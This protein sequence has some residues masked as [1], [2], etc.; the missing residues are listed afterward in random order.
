MTASN[1]TSRSTAAG[2]IAVTLALLAGCGPSRPATYPVT[3]KVVFPDGSTLPGGMV[4]FES[5]SAEGRPVNARGPIAEDGTFFLSTFQ[6]GDGA[7]PG[8]H[9]ALV[10]PPVPDVYVEEGERPPPAMLDRKYERYETS[11]LQFSVQ[12]GENQITINVTRP[13]R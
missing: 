2:A 10:R 11:D 4:E 6:P 13:G 12:E 7:L 9:R 8:E 5:I 1:L 3:G